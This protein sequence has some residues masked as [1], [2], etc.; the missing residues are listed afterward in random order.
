MERL[1]DDIPELEHRLLL[2]AA[3]ELGADDAE[4]VERELSENPDA[5]AALSGLRALMGETQTGLAAVEAKDEVSPRAVRRASDRAVRA[6]FGWVEGEKESRLLRSRDRGALAE[7]A[8][9]RYARWPLAAAAVLVVGLMIWTFGS[10]PTAQREGL[11]QNEPVT[12]APAPEDGESTASTP[13]GGVLPVIQTAL[14]QLDQVAAMFD[15]PAAR[16][17]R[18]EGADG[19]A[20]ELGSGLSD[21]LAALRLLDEPDWE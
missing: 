15:N 18:D 21:E 17:E 14:V 4:Q 13:Q 7:G 5:R 6:V 2:Y 11:A 19:L 16:F 8:V 3:G 12:P 9:W 1:L 20:M 10:D